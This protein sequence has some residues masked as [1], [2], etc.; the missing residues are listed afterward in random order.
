MKKFYKWIILATL[1]VAALIS[2]SYGFS[3]GVATFIVLGVVLELSFW[4][5]V[6]GENIKRLVLR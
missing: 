2:Y 4:L 1:L 6:F 3:H 5:G